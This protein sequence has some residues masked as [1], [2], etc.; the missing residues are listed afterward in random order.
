[1]TKYSFRGTVFS[2]HSRPLPQFLSPFLPFPPHLPALKWPKIQLKDFG[3][4][5]NP[6]RKR[7]FGVFRAQETCLVAA[8]IAPFPLN[9]MYKLKQMWLFPTFC[10]HCMLPC[11]RVLN[12]P[13]LFFFT[14]YF[15]GKH[16]ASYAVAA[17]SCF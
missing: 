8:N 9:E 14:F 4:A 12:Y 13:R 7:T 15:G 1:M 11:S 6:G 16:R 3:S 10:M 17:K 5:I 2:R